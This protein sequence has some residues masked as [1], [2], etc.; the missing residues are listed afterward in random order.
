MIVR[1]YT[2]PTNG[3]LSHVNIFLAGSIEMGKASPWQS[4]VISWMTSK[5]F[6][7]LTEGREISVFNPRR[8]EWDSSWEQKESNP[9]F[10]EQVNW[11]L[12][13]I[14]QSDIVFMYLDPATKSPISLL[15]LG[16]CK[17]KDIIVCCP[18][19][20][21]RRG[22]VEIVCSRYGI[23]LYDNLESALGSLRT[24]ILKKLSK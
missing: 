11:E 12:H 13:Y 3:S 24:Q 14:E 2:P 4:D 22:N 20:F 19:G 16:L 18:P 15:E 7:P 17:D 8:E 5:M 23:P 10:N 1:G 21:W 9:Q 6:I